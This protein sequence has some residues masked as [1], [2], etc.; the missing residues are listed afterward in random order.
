MSKKSEKA[1]FPSVRGAPC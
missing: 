1:A